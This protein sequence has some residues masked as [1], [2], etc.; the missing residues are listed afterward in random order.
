MR[1]LNSWIKGKIP[2][3]DFDG[4]QEVLLFGRFAFL[5]FCPCF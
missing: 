3:L 2:M 5:F 1:W 4:I